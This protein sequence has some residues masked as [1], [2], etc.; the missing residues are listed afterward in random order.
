MREYYKSKYVTIEDLPSVGPT[1]ASKLREMGFSTVESVAIATPKEIVA[2]G[3]GDK[4]ARKIIKAARKAISI[5]FIR[6]DELQRIR[7]NVLHLTTGSRTLDEIMGGGVET[8]SITEFYGEFGSGKCVA[9]DT[10]VLFFNSSTPQI[11]TIS[12]VYERYRQ[13]Y[14][15]K[16]YGN[17]FVVPAPSLKVIAFTGERFERVPSPYLYREGVKRLLRIR[18]LRGRELRLTRMHRLLTVTKAGLRWTKA[19]DLRSACP[20]ALPA[21]LEMGSTSDLSP[22]DAYFIG[23]FVA[24]GT[25][26]PLSISTARSEVAKWIEE[27][28]R[29]RFGFN[30]RVEKRRRSYRVLLRKKCVELLGKL[31]ECSASERYVPRSVLGANDS[32]AKHFLAGYLEGD[33]FLSSAVEICT[34]SKRLAIGLSYLLL[35]LGIQVTR[36]MKRTPKGIYYRLFIVGEDR[37]KLSSVPFRFSRYSIRTRGGAYGYPAAIAD[38]IRRVYRETLGGGRGPIRK[39]RAGYKSRTFYHVFTRRGIS[40]RQSFI[41]RRVLE[42]IISF[43]EEGL[44]RLEEIRR[45]LLVDFDRRFREIY[46]AIP[47]PFRSLAPAVGLS[48]SGIG[49]YVTRACP[50]DERRRSE[51]RQALLREINL[52]IGKLRAA[53]EELTKLSQFSWD[54][55]VEVSEI[56]YDDFVYDFVVPK[57]H[58]FIG[59]EIPTLLHNSQLCHQ[60]CVTA[61]LPIEQGGLDGGALYIDTE[62]S[63][64]VERIGQIARRF[65]LEPERVLH[66][67]IYA[68]AYTSLPGSERVVVLNSG[69]FR[70]LPIG[71]VRPGGVSVQ[72]FAFDLENGEMS[73]YPVTG[74]IRHRTNEPLYRIRTEY[75]REITVTGSH[76]LF[77][78]VRFGKKRRTTARR[79]GNM[80][81]VPFP[82]SLLKVGDRVAIPARLP[83]PDHDVDAIDLYDKLAGK[84]DVVTD[85]NYVMLRHTGRRPATR[86][87]RLSRITHDLLWLLGFFA[88]EGSYTTAKGRIRGLRFHSE[89]ELLEKAK[90]VLENEFQI[91]NARI[92]YAKPSGLATR[93]YWTLKVESRLLA[94]VFSSVFGLA[95]ASSTEKSIPP[96]VMELPK[97]KIKHFLMGLWEGDGHHNRPKERRILFTTPSKELAEQISLCLL[98]FGIVASIYSIPRHLLRPDQRQAYRVEARALSTNN[99]LELEEATQN[100][101]APRFGDIVFAKV[102]SI[103][104]LPVKPQEVFDFEVKVEGK[105]V[106]NFVGGYGGVCC[107]NSDHQIILLEKADKWIKEHN[108]KLVI[109]DSLTSNFRSDFIGR[110]MLAERQQKLNRHMHKL[111][112]LARAFNLSGVVT[113]QVMSRPDVVWAGNIVTPI[114]GHIV[115]HTTTTRVFLRKAKGARIARLVASPYLPEREARFRITE[116]GIEDIE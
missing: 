75:G 114:G 33:G 42:E 46:K 31:S 111:L 1:I 52:R 98:K 25:S 37:N 7:G 103:E 72:T 90:R 13:Q 14:G 104:E 23:L 91:T 57:G 85:G 99:I 19:T 93:P 116:N 10:Q 2:A 58:T 26:K 17:G 36:S 78:G 64:R 100:L 28:L 92:Y 21:R 48:K 89:K 66:N 112:R 95:H 59:G 94:L 16:P 32:V 71:S 30:P 88:A 96:W 22:D 50:R 113:N 29:G 68:E 60:L 62:Q 45:G 24:E 97:S 51:I 74:F 40:R 49:N 54:L 27:Y 41:S 47:F 84:Y 6:A 77:I 115:A 80:R 83:I 43:F 73:V 44:K 79:K 9:K 8:Q 38:Y 5:E 65:G 63:F 106:E 39:F 61:Q 105:S 102:K 76:S 56:P 70:Q 4:T 81:P 12:E 86:I 82:A 109:I 108:I 3:I 69:H 87:P 34:K 18:T 35:K 53:V 107:H 20:V 55:V 110:E 15:E 101:H 67:I 11:G